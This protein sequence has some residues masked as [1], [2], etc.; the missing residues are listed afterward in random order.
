MSSSLKERIISA[1]LVGVLF[2]MML[3]I[4]NKLIDYREDWLSYSAMWAI[5]WAIGHFVGESFSLILT[6]ESIGKILIYELALIF[7]LGLIVAFI[8][9]ILMNLPTWKDTLANICI[10][11]AVAFLINTKWKRN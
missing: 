10:P 1:L 11:F 5:C 4:T 8:V 9:G 2:F 7:C 6:D 3:C